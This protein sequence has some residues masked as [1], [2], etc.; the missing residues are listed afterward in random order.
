MIVVVEDD[1]QDGAD[2]V[3]A[4][5]MPAL[6][7]SPYAKKSAVVHTRYDFPSFIRTMEI[8]LGM[9]PLTINDALATPLYDAF[10][11]TADNGDP[12]AAIKPAQDLNERNAN[13]PANRAAVRGLDLS[14][15]DRVPQRQLDA[16]LWHSIHGFR[17]QPPPPG[18]NASGQDTQQRDNGG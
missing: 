5:R 14:A 12:Y 4:H 13:T 7:I 16:M 6:I 10:S 1:S 8:V 18:P 11:P 17:S 9:K 3:D 2:H 15:L